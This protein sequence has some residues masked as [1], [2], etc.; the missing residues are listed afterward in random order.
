V[1]LRV[2]P[3][4]HYADAEN[5]I[6]R[7]ADVRGLAGGEAR[8]GTPSGEGEQMKYFAYDREDGMHYFATAEEAKKHA[9]TVLGWHADY[10]GSEGWSE[11]VHDVC[12]GV[13]SESATEVD[14]KERPAVV[15]EDGEDEDGDY[16]PSEWSYRCN[17]KLLPSP[18]KGNEASKAVNAAGGD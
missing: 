1:P 2:L 7:R 16:W 6:A 9:E 17:Y 13:V 10:A 14:K 4:H 15:N 3:H 18:E 12:W 11:D 5:D 8:K